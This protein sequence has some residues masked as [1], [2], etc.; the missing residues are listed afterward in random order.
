MSSVE[1]EEV[2]APVAVRGGTWIQSPR[3]SR[4][5]NTGRDGRVERERG[6]GTQ[7]SPPRTDRRSPSRGSPR[8]SINSSSSPVWRSNKSPG[9]ERNSGAREYGG[10][11]D[12]ERDTARATGAAEAVVGT[13][14]AQIQ[15]RT[16]VRTDV[17]SV[18]RYSKKSHRVSVTDATVE[19]PVKAYIMTTNEATNEAANEAANE[20]MPEASVASMAPN[21]PNAPNAPTTLTAPNAFTA[22]VASVAPPIARISPMVSLVSA[23]PKVYSSQAIAEKQ[24]KLDELVAA[25]DALAKRAPLHRSQPHSLRHSQQE[26]QPQAHARAPPV[27]RN[28]G[29]SMVERSTVER[30]TV[31][32]S[33]VESSTGRKGGGHPQGV[34]VTPQGAM[35][36]RHA[37]RGATRSATRGVDSRVETRV[38]EHGE[39]SL[40]RSLGGSNSGLTRSGEQLKEAGGRGEREQQR[41]EHR[42]VSI[43]RVFDAIDR[44]H[45]GSINVRELIL[46]CRRDPTVAK[47]LHLPVN[48]HQE[49]GSRETFEY[50][51]QA[52]DADGSRDISWGEFRDFLLT[53]SQDAQDAQDEREG[54][55]EG[56]REG[57]SGV[58]LQRTVGAGRGTR[59]DGVFGMKRVGGVVGSSASAFRVTDRDPATATAA[60]ADDTSNSVEANNVITNTNAV[61]NA[62]VGGISLVDGTMDGSDGIVS[63]H[64]SHVSRLPR[65]PSS[66]FDGSSPS[67]PAHITSRATSGPTSGTSLVV[68]RFGERGEVSDGGSRDSNDDHLSKSLFTERTME[69]T[70][71]SELNE[72]ATDMTDMLPW[73]RGAG[74]EGATA[75]A[76][77]SAPTC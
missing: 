60:L 70:T 58:G 49:D 77:S 27:S 61:N 42:V 36:E 41:R 40:E 53:E 29:S 31:E 75:S 64:V 10:A 67:S 9:R 50:R 45:D 6:R 32:R 22:S 2:V 55:R 74:S 16:E 39:R 48:V 34:M 56:V 43:R 3:R 20:A 30:S 13:R 28:T 33:M 63:S 69:R 76:P 52:M 46:S 14:G 1:T 62:V 38:I 12:G 37:T 5:R 51:F 54:V 11:D 35:V 57:K 44:N 68:A 21:A 71:I 23:R 4:Q 66:F 72:Q 24:R 26:Q 65:L 7:R 59:T 15:D 25:N 47:F 17:R 19:A 73:E 18:R 8:S